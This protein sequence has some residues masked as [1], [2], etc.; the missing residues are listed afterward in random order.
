MNASIHALR[1]YRDRQGI[2]LETLAERVGCSKSWLS[3]IEAGI[4]QA[5]PAL[6]AKLRA[7]TGLS[8]DD[9]IPAEAAE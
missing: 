8:A 1:K 7:E 2:T 3:R 4:D 6:I 9:F 5:S